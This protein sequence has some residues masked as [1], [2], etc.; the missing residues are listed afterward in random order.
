VIPHE[1]LTWRG[2]QGHQ[3]GDEVEGIE[4]QLFGSVSPGA[5][6]CQGDSVAFE[7]PNRVLRNCRSC[8][9]A[10]WAFEH[11]LIVGADVDGGVELTCFN[12]P[13]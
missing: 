4:D 10:T 3:A 12:A 5:A 9:V 11:V 7:D 2:D 13:V 6:Q 8:N 1:V